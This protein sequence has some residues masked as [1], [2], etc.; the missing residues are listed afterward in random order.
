MNEA[1][2]WFLNLNSR[3][4]LMLAIGG[5][6]FLI[7]ILLFMIL[8]PMQGELERKKQGNLAAMSEQQRVHH[9]AGQVLG[10]EQQQSNGR[11]TQQSLNA[12]LNSSLRQFGLRMES[13][14][15]SG[16]T[17]RVRL[18]SSEFNKVLAWLDEME[19]KKGVQIRDLTI[20]ADNDPGAVLVNLQIMQGG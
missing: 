18:S 1:K 4:Q 20:T 13:F 10:R 7:Y 14:Q 16:D 15:P 2:E 12:L 8:I 17:A 19:T 3:D 6:A 11:D 9:L 5:F